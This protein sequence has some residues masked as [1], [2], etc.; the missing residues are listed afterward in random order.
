MSKELKDLI[1]SLDSANRA[2]SDLET[3]IKY[4]K[5]EV[6]KLNFTIKE[7]K[8]IIQS[9]KVQ[10]SNFEESAIPEDVQVLTELVVSQREEIVKKDKDVEILTQTIEEITAELENAQ[11]F[12]EDNEELVYSNKVIVQLT[13]ENEMNRIKIYDLE[14]KIKEL[15]EDIQSYENADVKS[16]NQQLIDTKKLIFQLTEENGLNRVQIESLKAEVEDLNSSLQ[17][18]ELNKNQYINELEQS[19]KEVENLRALYIEF[20][21]KVDYLQNK[22]EETKKM[23]EIPKDSSKFNEKL[24]NLET[25]NKELKNI[26]ETNIDII[27]NLKDENIELKKTLEETIQMIKLKDDNYLEKNAENEKKLEDLNKKLRII[28]TA[29]K[30]LSDLI[31]Q[32]KLK[33][34]SLIKQEVP[35]FESHTIK[36]ES[37]PIYIPPYL[38][39]EM[40]KMLDKTKKEQIIDQLIQDL[41]ENNIRDK[42][43]YALKILSTI[44]KPR[45]FEAFKKLIKDKD[46]II[47]LYIIKALHN[48]ENPEVENVLK[49]LQ[50]DSDVDVREAAGKLLS[51]FNKI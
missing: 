2:H 38:F 28:Q 3:I 15:Q 10:L 41:N 29:N 46:W 26:I 4:L 9:Q 27:E 33:D 18:S 11:K 51:K 20:K 17:E 12:D 36:A 13:E 21:E 45:I 25:E 47:K 14:E 43:V 8:R 19:N 7:Q 22:L 49:E 35:R 44:D 24:L 37:R 1:D 32:L 30:K 39:H 50:K 5:E 16:L 6:Q 42:R 34:D 48:F 23:H 40:F 31:V